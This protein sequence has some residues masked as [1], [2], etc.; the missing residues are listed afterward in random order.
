MIPNRKR[1][2]FLPGWRIFTYLI[3]ASQ[4]LMLG[5]LVASVASAAWHLD[6]GPLETMTCTDGTNAGPGIAALLVI[7]IWALVTLI[8]G[9]LWLNTGHDKPHPCPACGHDVQFRTFECG[10]C[11]RLPASRTSHRSASFRHPLHHS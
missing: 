4:V 6:C 5:W 7:T 1:L 2:G 10:Q 9:A 11:L 8:L 3:I